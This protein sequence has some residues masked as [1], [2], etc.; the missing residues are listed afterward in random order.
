MGK[1]NKKKSSRP[2]RN[3]MTS[4]FSHNF[5][6]S[7]TLADFDP[8]LAHKLSTAN[9]KQIRHQ[10]QQHFS[11]YLVVENLLSGIGYQIPKAKSSLK[12]EKDLRMVFWEQTPHLKSNQ[13]T[14]TNTKGFGSGFGSQI[15]RGTCLKSGIWFPNPDPNPFVFVLGF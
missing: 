14:D 11:M 12:G 5:G 2:R 15:L 6:G 7:N 3:L 4:G 13:N 9:P 1:N 8:V 10:T